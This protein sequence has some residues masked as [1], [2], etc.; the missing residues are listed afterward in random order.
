MRRNFTRLFLTVFILLLISNNGVAQQEQQIQS[1]STTEVVSK[2][3]IKKI[4]NKKA[5]K[6]KEGEENDMYDGPAKAAE[7][8]F[9]RTKNPLTNDVPAGKMWNAVEQTQQQKETAA[10]TAGRVSALN[11]IERGSNTDAVGPSNGNTRANN[12]KTSGRIDA[13]MVDSS[14]ATHKTVWV[15]GRDGGLWKTTDITTA[16]ANW[17]LVNDYFGNLSIAAITQDPTNYNT[18]YFCTGESY[19]ESNALRGNGVFKSTDHGVTWNRLASTASYFYCTR[20]LCDYLGN[21]YL[22]TRG[23]GLLRSTNGGTSWTDITPAGLSG[24]ICDLEITSTAAASRL[25]LVTGIFSTQA[26]RYT[27]IAATVS[28]TF[29]W[30]APAT[31]FPSFAM[32]AEIGVSGNILYAAPADASF[33]VPT[34]YKSTD[35]GANWAATAGQPT[36]GWAS[37]QGWYALT[38]V[39]NPSNPNECFVGGLDQHKTTDGGATWTRASFWVGTT[40]QYV[41]ADQH[42]ALWYDGGSKLIFGCDGGIHFSSDGGTT[43]TDRNQGL[44]LKQFYSAAIHPD[45]VGSPNYFLAGAQDNGTHQF[46]GAGLTS[47]VEV[48]GGDGAYVGIDKDEPQ[49]QI[50]AYVYSN[51]R[52]T[53]NGGATWLYGPSNNAGQFINSFDY[54]NANNKVYSSYAAGQYLRW[55]NPQSGFTYTSVPVANFNG[56][57]VSAVTSSP[58]IANR[59]YFGTTGGRVV[60]ADN[61]NAAPTTVNLTPAGMTGFVNAVAIGSSDQYLAASITSYGVNNIWVSSNGGSSWTAC[62]GNLPDMPVYWAFFDPADNNRLFIATET[63]VWET[64]LLNGASTIWVPHTSFPTVRTTMLKYRST[65][66]TLLASTYGRGLWTTALCASAAITAQPAST[67]VCVSTPVNFTVTA[68]GDPTLA[69]QWQLSTNGGATWANIAGATTNSYS[70]PGV[71]AADNGKKFRCY[72]TNGCPSSDTSAAATLTAATGSTGGALSPASVNACVGPNSTTLTLTGYTGNVLNWESSTDGGITWVSIANTTPTLTVTNLTQTTLYRANVQSTGCTASFSS[73][74]T[75]TFVPVGLG[76]IFVAADNGTVVC[77]GTPTRLTVQSA[78]SSVAVMNNNPTSVNGYVLFNFK[79]NNAFPVTVTGIASIANTPGTTKVSAYYNTTALTGVVAPITIANGW[80]QFGGATINATGTVQPFMSGLS[81]VI[82]AGATYA[83]A[84]SATDATG[85]A[86]NFVYSNALSVPIASAGGCDIITNNTI[87]MAGG[88]IPSA[89]VTL[90]RFFIGSITVSGAPTALPGGSTFAWSPAAGLNATNTNPVA[91]SPAVTTNYTVVASNGSG[92]T[93]T[94]SVNI[95]VNQRPAITVQ[96][97]NTTACSGTAATF[98]IDATGSGT[99]GTGITYQWQE[100]TDGGVTYTNLANA[101]AYAGVTT[102]TLNIITTSVMNNNRYRCVVSGICSPNATSAGAV[103]SVAASPVVTVTPTSGCGGV[104]GV[105]G[106]KLVASSGVAAPTITSTVSSGAI[107]L[108]VPDNTAA[109]VNNTLNVAGIPAGAVISDMYVTLNMSH[110]Y[111]GDMIFNLKGPGGQI[112]NLYKYAGGSF[113]GPA[114]GPA[115]WGWYN[116]EIHAAGGNAFNSISAPYVYNTPPNWKADA[117]NTTV[118]N[119]TIQNPAGFVSNAAGFSD[120]YSAINGGWTLAMCD[121]GGGDV[122]TLAS[123]TITIKYSVPLAGGAAL[124]Y[125]WSPAAGL[126]TDPAAT[127]PYVAGSF[128][129]S[130]YAAPAANTVY[131]VIGNNAV[132]GCNSN[133]ATATVNY[134]PVAPTVNPVA[135]VMCLGSAAVPL[136]ITSSLLPVTQ[137]FSSGTVNVAIPDGPVLPAPANYV[138][139]ATTTILPVTG[140][141]VGAVV[142]GISAKFNITHTYSSDLVMVLKAPNGSIFN[143]DA[144]LNK[145]GKPG[146]NFTNTVISS[147]GT[148]LLSSGSAPYTGT[149]APD[150]IVGTFVTSGLIFPAGPA[151]Y[152]PTTSVFNDLYSTPNGNWTLAVYDYGSGDVGT[153]NNWSIDITYGVASSGIWTPNGAGSGLFTDAAATIPYTGTALNTVYAKP[154]ASTTYS[155]VVNTGSCGSAARQVPVTV[156]APVTI[157]T[158]PADAAVCANN[159]TSLVVKTTGNV[160]SHNWQVRTIANGPWVN[161]ANG[162]LY[163]GANTATLTITA[164][165]VSITGYFYRDSIAGASPCGFSISSAAKLTVYPLPVI[166]ISANPTKLFPGLKTIINSTVGPNAAATYTWLKNGVIVG[167]ATT[168]SLQLDVDK[169]GDYSLR[170]QDVNGCIGTSNLLPITDSVNNKVFIYPNP[171][172]GQFQVRYYSGLNN[173]GLPRGVN[174]YDARGKRIL[175]KLYSIG[176]PYARMDVDLTNH[177]T[178]VYTVEV[179]D[180]NGNRLAIGRVEIVR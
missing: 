108:A 102:S 11:W 34:I 103:L 165:P 100:S 163:G 92:C 69:Y 12:G 95:L 140:I 127:I 146:A 128:K 135:A 71:V 80:N 101:G 58:Y 56:A 87:G 107:N 48:T 25:H 62:D 29:G 111:P 64:A 148:A 21:V 10:A 154:A 175:T 7:F 73:P 45:A 19:F 96:P 90:R 77:A 129:D 109:G 3:A 4:K 81:L 63:G 28:S 168:A 97:V 130:V 98:I 152:L 86:G 8:Q 89:P 65:D 41:H 43:I 106:L 93:S 32:R 59:V 174:I 39:I 112:L 137:T 177:G 42:K 9:N 53:T 20:I 70:L 155:V 134:T 113:T 16:P 24:N 158:Q 116:A 52:R 46:N 75:I 94:A 40:G 74:S 114:S 66:R 6:E 131:S 54:D 126:F 13:L 14:D 49:Y 91:A 161:I 133:V 104:A 159:V 167:G 138:F 132:T 84:V 117:L 162:A 79:N 150:A 136:T 76:P 26:Y 36:A 27:D 67:T 83:M 15:G 143:L 173:I 172:S 160:A 145:S 44:R 122:G 57:T 120:F 60:M 2:K 144:A 156:N 141:P 170:V 169:L 18:M 35:G 1:A 61:A 149:F 180:V 23:N 147:S 78:A 5:R 88:L 33:Q 30:T 17:T 85:T 99:N 178:G 121:G 47:S 118:A 110:T 50:A 51:Y 37:G 166:T 22:G 164:P 153:I 124:N 119:T 55:E 179:V 171:N 139:P 38:V 82:P 176:S 125:T 72:V 151:G 105:N 115:T 123:W 68:S 142:S 157:T 31:P